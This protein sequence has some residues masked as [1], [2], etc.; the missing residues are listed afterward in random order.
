[1][2]KLN[3]RL[4]TQEIESSVADG[5]GKYLSYGVRKNVR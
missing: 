1:M 3:E 5:A 2:V 4:Y